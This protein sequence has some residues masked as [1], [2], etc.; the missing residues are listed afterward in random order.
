VSPLDFLSADLLCKTILVSC[1]PSAFLGNALVLAD[2]FCD[3][4]IY[5][6]FFI[7]RSFFNFNNVI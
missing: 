1:A 4:V 3:V 7:C 2:V 5:P 6:R